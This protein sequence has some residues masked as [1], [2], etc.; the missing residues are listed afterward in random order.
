MDLLDLS[1]APVEYQKYA[2]IANLSFSAQGLGWAIHYFLQARKSLRDKTYSQA[3]FPLC[4]NM[5]WEFVYTFIYP[6]KSRIH[7]TIMGSWF[8]LGLIV[9]YSAVKSSPREWKHTT[10]VQRYLPIIFAVVLL[11]FI[12][13]HWAFAETWGPAV[14]GPWSAMFCQ[15]LL[16]WGSLSQLLVREDSRGTSYTI[17][18]TRFLGTLA[19]A[20][21]Q[22]LRYRYWPEQFAEISYGIILWRIRRKEAQDVK[23]V[24]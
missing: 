20:P 23:K 9:M 3:I 11:Y 17:W 14:T 19:G 1:T 8:F 13:L 10:L 6:P 2:W 24:T 21:G 15:E 18:L 16:L 4:A 5:A 22:S 7:A 12:S